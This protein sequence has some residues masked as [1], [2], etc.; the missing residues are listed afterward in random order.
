VM[1]GSAVDV[2]RAWTA[3][4]L[5]GFSIN[6]L[7]LDYSWSDSGGKNSN[8]VF[9]TLAKCM[10][11]PDL[12]L[13]GLT[14]GLH[15]IILG[16]ATIKHIQATAARTVSGSS[17]AGAGA[18]GGEHSSGGTSQPDVPTGTGTGGGSTGG[19]G[20]GGHWQLPGQS[21]FTYGPAVDSA[22]LSH[23]TPVT[24]VGVHEMAY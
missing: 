24:I 14:P 21:D 10:N 3:G 16:D 7:N 20:G 13:G 4:Q 17:G 22:T 18:G 2:M 15:D 6:E 11:L 5:C 12:D 23:Q 1:D 9:S 8:A 19:S